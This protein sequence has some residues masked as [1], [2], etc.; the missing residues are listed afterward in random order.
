LISLVV[1]GIVAL[2]FYLTGAIGVSLFGVCGFKIS[3]FSIFIETVLILIYLMIV[4]ISLLYFRKY[5]PKVSVAE[6]DWRLFIRY[7][8]RY[9]I[10]ISI[11][12]IV[13][14]VSN[15][16]AAINCLSTKPH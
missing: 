11:S 6:N 16:I 12:A 9:I 5:I 8:F 13:R 10:T 15:L 2:I 7:Y 14:C 1:L 4:I 3:V